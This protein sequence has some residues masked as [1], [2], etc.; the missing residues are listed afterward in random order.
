MLRYRMSF[1]FGWMDADDYGHTQPEKVAKSK[2]FMSLLR[3]LVEGGKLG[4]SLI[5]DSELSS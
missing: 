4:V 3:K 2:G 5:Y 1:L